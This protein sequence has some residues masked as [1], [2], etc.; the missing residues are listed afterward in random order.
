[1]A[2]LLPDSRLE[3]L[4]A[5]LT[6]NNIDP[7]NVWRDG[8][9]TVVTKNDQR[10]IVYEAFDLTPDGKR[11]MDERGQH[12]AVKR[13]ETPLLVEPPDWWQPYEKPTREQLLEA[14]DRVRKLHI[15][16]AHTGDCEYCSLRDYP[17][18]SVPYPCDTVQALNGTTPKGEY[19]T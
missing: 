14:A 18:Y 9:L 15:E 17:D 5:W 2:K 1:M 11:Q 10:V 4:R 8:V 7:M 13:C 3:A 6:A 16:N 19:P 12:V